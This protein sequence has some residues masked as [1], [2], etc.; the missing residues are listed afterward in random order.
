VTLAAHE[1]DARLTI[2]LGVTLATLDGESVRMHDD[3]ALVETKSEDGESPGDQALAE[4]GAHSV[5]LSKYRTGIDALLRRDETG[6]LAEARR[7]FT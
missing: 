4:V 3:L 6:E 5:S 2:D 7:L 1:G